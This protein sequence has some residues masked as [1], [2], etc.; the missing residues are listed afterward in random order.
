MMGD[1]FLSE[2]LVNVYRDKLIESIHRGDVVVVDKNGNNVYTVGDD[3]KLTYWRSAAKPFQALPLIYTG[4]AEKYDFTE[5]ELAIMAASHSGEPKHVKVIRDILKKIN[6]T[7]NYLKCGIHPPLHKESAEELYKSGKEP[8]PVHNNCSGKHC[9]LLALSKYHGW[10]LTNYNDIHHPAQRLI[11]KTISEISGRKED[12]IYYGEDGCGVPVFGLTIKEMA[13]AYSR[14]ANPLLLP[15]KYRDAAEIITTGMEKYPDMI[16]GTDR[17]NTDLMK[18]T[19]R[20]LAAKSG[21]EGVF[22]IGVHGNVGITVKI[23][24]GNKRA[25][26]PVILKILFNLNIISEEEVK[27]LQKYR[28]PAVMN[29]LGHKVGKITADFKFKI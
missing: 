17:F 20:K 8:G 19:G 3:Q 28:K 2:I 5:K 7:E 29:N 11:I 16:G 6:L 18:V 21:A 13:F 22:C 15:V 12:S 4:A 10:S 9:A 1:D 23:E 25:V 24:D 27:K 14:L 26:P